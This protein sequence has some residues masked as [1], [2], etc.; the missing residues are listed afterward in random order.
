MNRA[1]AALPPLPFGLALLL[2]LAMAISP[3]LSGALAPTRTVE[4]V[5][6]PLD[7]GIPTRVADWVVVPSPVAQT[8]LDLT[9]DGSGTDNSRPYD[10]VVMRNY[11]NGAGDIAMLAIAYARV[12]RQE[13]KIHRPDLCYRSQGFAL[14]TVE[15]ARFGF[16]SIGGRPV[17]GR[18][19]LAQR[20]G[21][22]EAV[23][24]WLRTG[25]QYSDA[26]WDA[27]MQILLDGLDG[28]V[29][30][31]VLVRA[32]RLIASP[33]EATATWLQLEAFLADIAAGS[34]DEIRPLLLR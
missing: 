33:A 5:G 7:A 6:M 25:E 27:R 13:V 29:P 10:Q 18:R 4:A 23:V 12:Q 9:G 3:L 15:P 22:L 11:R 14:L 16:T 8:G 34:S 21:R 30:D 2:A 20:A 17:I 32:S 26:S 31:G 24:Y 28:H 1:L 19:L